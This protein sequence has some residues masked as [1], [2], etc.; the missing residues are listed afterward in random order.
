[1]LTFELS[2]HIIL[3][4]LKETEIFPLVWATFGSC[5]PSLPWHFCCFFL[6]C[7]LWLFC[8]TEL[9]W[10]CPLTASMCSWSRRLCGVALHRLLVCSYTA[11][12]SLCPWALSWNMAAPKRLSLRNPWQRLTSSSAVSSRYFLFWNYWRGCGT[13]KYFWLQLPLSVRERRQIV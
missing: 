10:P 11:S 12:A 5:L 1:M 9:I 4:S 3:N 13:C 7:L 2:K 6:F 8:M